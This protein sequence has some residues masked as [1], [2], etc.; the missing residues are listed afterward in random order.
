MS[1][2]SRRIIQRL[3]EELDIIQVLDTDDV[4][5]LAHATEV[6]LSSGGSAELTNKGGKVTLTLSLD[7]P[8]N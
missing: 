7:A 2:D 5:V 3:E 8:I 6:I 1:R 4:D